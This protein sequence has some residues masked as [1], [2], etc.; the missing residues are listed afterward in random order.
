MTSSWLRGKSWRV[1]CKLH[2]YVI[3]SNIIVSQKMGQEDKHSTQRC[4]KIIHRAKNSKKTKMEVLKSK[5]RLNGMKMNQRH[6]NKEQ[7]DRDQR[8]EGWEVMGERRGRVKLRNMCEG[9]MDKDNGK[10]RVMG[11]KWRQL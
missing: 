6:G 1:W 7:T 9:P 2:G 11:G 3:D 10:G 8:G 4:S 5:H